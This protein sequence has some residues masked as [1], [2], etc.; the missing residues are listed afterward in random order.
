MMTRDDY[1]QLQIDKEIFT[2]EHLTKLTE[3][4]QR[5]HSLEI[6]GKCG[7]ATLKSILGDEITEVAEADT[8]PLR[9]IGEWEPFYGPLD[10]L[11]RNRAD[12]YKLLG[13]PSNG[14]KVNKA[15]YKENIREFRKEH[16]LPGVPPHRYIKMHKLVE[17]YAREALRRAALVSDYTIHTFGDFVYRHIRHGGAGTPLSYHS[18]GAA[19]DVNPQDNKAKSFP[20]GEA[21]DPW[22][23]EWLEIWPRGVDRAFVEAIES[24]GWS[25]GGRWSKF[26]DGMHFQL[27]I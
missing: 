10:Y 14:S 27:S 25:W 7:P 24:V 15:W 13:N 8:D 20:E 5:D 2:G 18:W 19:F 6:D 9:R 1:N 17:P 16:A 12:L 26:K 3:L 23:D 22:S 11:P 21:P 4:W